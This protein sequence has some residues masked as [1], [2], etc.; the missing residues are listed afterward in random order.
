MLFVFLQ[1]RTSAMRRSF[2]PLLFGALAFAA[3]LALTSTARAD[4]IADCG[5]IDVSAQADCSVVVDVPTCQAQCTPVSFTAAC[6]AKCTATV[7]S[8]NVEC[9]GSCSG[10]CT[11]NPGTF[12]CETDCS[13]KC[14]GNCSSYCA[15]HS[16]DASCMA[17]CQGSCTG[18]CKAQCSGTPPTAAC[19]AQCKASCSGS[20]N[21]QANVDCD[22]K[23]D[24]DLSGGCNL[25]C[26]QPKGALFCNSSYVDTNGN[27]D[28][29]VSALKAQLNITVHGYADC[30]G[31]QCSA[32]ASASCAASPLGPTGLGG[33]GIAGL[34][35]GIGAI[36]ARRRRRS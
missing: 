25:Q 23:C 12:N 11:A 33:Y 18:E 13:G 31:N 3:P 5:N 15:A 36:V 14:D 2:A 17:N 28:K 20:C 8:C 26:T 19:D 27:L 1:R 30:S 34:I 10:S 24:A 16:G 6:D 22:V 35:A 21:V 4:S 9:E 7:P 32:G 29:C